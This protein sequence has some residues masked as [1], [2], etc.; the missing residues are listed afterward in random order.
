MCTCRVCV[1][2]HMQRCRSRK[3]GQESYIKKYIRLS[4]SIYIYIHIHTHTYTGAY[5]HNDNIYYMIMNTYIYIYT[6]GERL[7]LL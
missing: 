5:M 2:M 1:P 3:P 4:L 6:Q 7:E